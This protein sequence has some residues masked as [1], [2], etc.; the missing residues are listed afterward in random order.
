MIGSFRGP[1]GNLG[2]SARLKNLTTKYANVK[3]EMTVRQTEFNSM[4][5]ICDMCVMA[6]E[7]KSQ[8]R[9]SETLPLGS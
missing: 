7:C 1:G 4:F 6:Y 2:F 3:S 9:K 8:G 5:E